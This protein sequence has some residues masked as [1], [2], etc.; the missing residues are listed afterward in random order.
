MMKDSLTLGIDSYKYRLDNR[1]KDAVMAILNGNYL[2]AE[3]ALGDC[4]AYE[5]VIK[6]LQYQRQLMEAD[7]A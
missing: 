7:N 4:I 5:A 3:S 6:E 2:T 1:R